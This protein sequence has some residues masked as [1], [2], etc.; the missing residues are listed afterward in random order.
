VEGAVTPGVDL[1]VVA[2]LGVRA[3][4]IE[5]MEPALAVVEVE[6]ERG[7][8]LTVHFRGRGVSTGGGHREGSV[9]QVSQ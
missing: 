4:V 1:D 2:W 5:A 7:S 9:I 8:A 3:E 6:E